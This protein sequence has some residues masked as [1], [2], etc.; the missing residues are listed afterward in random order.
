MNI[1]SGNN[2]TEKKKLRCVVII[3]N[4]LIEFN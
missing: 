3:C 2:K 1:Y 4:K